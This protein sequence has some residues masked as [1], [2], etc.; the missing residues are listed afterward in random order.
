MDPARID[1]LYKELFHPL[2]FYEKTLPFEWSQRNVAHS[3]IK[4]KNKNEKLNVITTI[5]RVKGTFF[6][7]D[8]ALQFDRIEVGFDI[9]TIDEHTEN[10]FSKDSLK[11]FFKEALIVRNEIAEEIRVK[12]DK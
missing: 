12:L 7:P 10:R 4:V 1:S 3:F 5:S 2:Y 11:E 6:E 9:N 8:A